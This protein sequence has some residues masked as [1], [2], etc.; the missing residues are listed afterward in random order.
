[1]KAAVLRKPREPLSIEDVKTP[2][3]GFGEV[4]VEVKACGLCHSDLHFMDGVRRTGKLPIILGHE[5]AGVVVEV[6]EGV[7]DVDVGDRVAIEYYFTCGRCRYCRTGNENLCENILRFGMDVDGAFAEYAKAPARN[8]VKVPEG[9]SMVDAAVSTDAVA[10]PYHAL[11]YVGE[12]RGGEWLV[13]YGIGGLGVHAVQIAKLFGANVVAVD[14]LEEKLG[15]ARRYGADYTVNASEVDPVEE[16]R[17]ITGGGADVAVDLA[18]RV[19]TVEYAVKSVRPL[20][21]VVCV[22]FPPESVPIDVSDVIVRKVVIKG[23]RGLRHTDLEEV[24]SLVA[25][26]VVKPVVSHRFRLEEINEGYERLRRGEL[27]RGVVVYG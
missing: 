4:L 25:K 2:R 5:A 7:T 21:R 15:L 14:V 13:V 17:A 1:M 20:G 23:S 27:I 22:G 26:G 8:V 11:R 24:L 18:G 16:V 3:P 10:T 12:L 9:V 6:G 19:E